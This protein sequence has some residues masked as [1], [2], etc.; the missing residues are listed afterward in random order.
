[1]FKYIAMIKRKEGISP[2]EFREYYETKHVPL[3][4][5]L[6]PELHRAITYR[7]NYLTFNDPLLAVDDRDGGSVDAGFDV[8]TELIFHNRQDAEIQIAAAF[9]QPDKFALVLEDE[10]HFVAPGHA[11]MYVVDVSETAMPS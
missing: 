1:M 5:K 11:K 4:L 7:R 9:K 6:F 10:A 3:L 8:L 2:A